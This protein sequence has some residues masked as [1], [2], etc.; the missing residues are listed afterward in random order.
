M[1]CCLVC[2][3]FRRVHV[4]RDRYFRILAV[5]VRASGK[6]R[7]RFAAEGH[8][9]RR[10]AVGFRQVVLEREAL[11]G[12]GLE[13]HDLALDEGLERLVP[14]LGV[15]QLRLE[16]LDLTG[17]RR[18]LRRGLR[19]VVPERTRWEPRAPPRRLALKKIRAN[20]YE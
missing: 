19:H 20:D 6:W 11:L 17:E 13:L 5:A 14:R 10:L 3:S 2:A 18:H 9:R 16:R 7:G 12:G 1:V 4:F 15:A 8:Q